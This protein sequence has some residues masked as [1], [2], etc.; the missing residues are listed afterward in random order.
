[1]RPLAAK[2]LQLFV[3]V[4]SALFRDPLKI[5]P[6]DSISFI[7]GDISLVQLPFLDISIYLFQYFFTQQHFMPMDHITFEETLS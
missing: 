6:A 2:S 4:I 5:S 7:S 1:M 3:A